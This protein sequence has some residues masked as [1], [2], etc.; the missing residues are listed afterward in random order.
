MKN[1]LRRSILAFT[2]AVI[3]LVCLAP[4]QA[5]AQYT[6]ATNAMFTL[7]RTISVTANGNSAL[8][9]TNVGYVGP[10]AFVL[11]V[12]NT[13]GTAP[14]LDV[15]LQHSTDNSTFTDITGASYPQVVTANTSTNMVIYLPI[16]YQNQFI[17]AVYTIG[18]SASPA[19]TISHH[20]LAAQKYR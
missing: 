10:A 3:A 2:L 6:F 12:T 17:R 4:R 15:K 16:E 14:T 1:F 20:V 19:F 5:R 8:V 9:F 18:G 13:A 7:Q 11:T